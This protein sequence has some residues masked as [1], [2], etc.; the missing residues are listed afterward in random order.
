ME[1]RAEISVISGTGSVVFVKKGEEFIRIGGWGQLFDTAGSAY[2]IGRDAI[3]TALSEEDEL[4]PYSKISKNLLRRL[5]TET[6]WSSIGEIYKKGKP[7]V[8]SLAEAVFEAYKDG[9]EGATNIIN[10]NAKRLAQEYKIEQNSRFDCFVSG[11]FIFG[12]Y[13]EA[14]FALNKLHTKKM[15]I[16]TLSMSQENVDS[17]ANLLHWGLVD[18]LNIVISAYFFAHER[19]RLIKYM[20][21]ELD[22]DNRFQLAVAGVHTKTCHFETDSGLKIVMHGSA[23]LRSSANVEQFTIEEHPQLFDFYEEF[24]D[25]IIEQY[26]TIKKPIRTTK[27]WDVVTTKKF[28]DD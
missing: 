19:N 13:I 2:D 24:F 1:P 20:Y 10:E 3:R 9:D 8:A 17:L 14:L 15:T 28:K 7:F 4:K 16:S 18:E 5:G 22:I 23:N 21:K 12:D 26:K 27:L 6:V 11:K 25:S